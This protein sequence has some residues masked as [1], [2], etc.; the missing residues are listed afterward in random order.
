[1]RTESR[2]RTICRK[3]RTCLILAVI[4]MLAINPEDVYAA[5]KKEI[6]SVYLY[7]TSE[8]EVGTQNDYVRVVSQSDRCWVDE[9]EVTNVPK[10]DWESDDEPRLKI[11][12]RTDEDY[13]FSS[14]ISKKK[15]NLSGDTGKVTSVSRKGSDKLIVYVTLDSLEGYEGSHSLEVEDLEWDEKSGYAYWDEAGDA[16]RYEVRLFRDDRE[17]TGSTIKTSNTYYDFSPRLTRNGYYC[18]KVR[19][20]Y[21][22]DE[23]G[24]WKTSE[25]WYVSSADAAL[26]SD[27]KEIL[28]VN[29]TAKGPGA[30]P[31][32]ALHSLLP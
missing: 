28:P 1:M 5:S 2:M 17:V 31:S 4:W 22:R 21:D 6:R 25:R 30:E 7:I 29:S 32:I 19:A 15:I 13:S 16:E 27:G 23:K 8:I 3:C 20:V 12:L 9:M 11:T 10:N 26:L 18:F 24:D 14:G